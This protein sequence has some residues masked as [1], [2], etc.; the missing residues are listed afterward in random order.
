MIGTI[1]HLGQVSPRRG[2]ICALLHVLGATLGAAALGVA[3]GVAGVG[4]RWGAAALGVAPFG[5]VGVGVGLGLLALLCGLRELGVLTFPLPQRPCQVP[6][7]WWYTMGTRRASFLWGVGIGFGLLT[8]ISYPVYYLVLAVALAGTPAYGGLLL[9][10]C[11]FGQGMVLLTRTV[12][13]ACR[14]E[15]AIRE[16]VWIRRMHRLAGGA[17]LAFGGYL[18]ACAW[19]ARLGAL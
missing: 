14:A 4:L 19:M 3:L 8:F 18:L 15:A 2:L 17:A 9:A 16:Q 10:A 13:S 5:P 7:R 11:G 6:R 1:G 12:Q